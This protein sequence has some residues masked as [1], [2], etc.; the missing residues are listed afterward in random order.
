MSCN[1]V[2]PVG[3][4]TNRLYSGIKCENQQVQSYLHLTRHKLNVRYLYGV[5]SASFAQ[6]TQTV[7]EY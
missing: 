4:L 2:T 1:L 6:Q 3:N 7:I 5:R